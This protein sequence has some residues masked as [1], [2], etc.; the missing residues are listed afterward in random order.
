[1]FINADLMVYLMNNIGYT[2]VVEKIYQQVELLSSM[3]YYH[4]THSTRSLYNIHD[5]GPS[6]TAPS[7]VY[8][9]TIG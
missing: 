9:R 5:I 3:N 4:S 6:S 1:M 2:I 7:T 8:W